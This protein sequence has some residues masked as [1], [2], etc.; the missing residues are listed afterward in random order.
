MGLFKSTLLN[1]GMGIPVTI[2]GLKASS[3]TEFQEANIEQIT[4]IILASY[5]MYLVLSPAP[6]IIYLLLLL[7]HNFLDKWVRRK[8]FAPADSVQ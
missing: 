4:I 1:E 5:S 8:V 3:L 7:R 6:G 2:Y